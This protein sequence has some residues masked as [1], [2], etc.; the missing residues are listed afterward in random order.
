MAGG[1]EEGVSECMVGG[2]EVDCSLV[3]LVESS[4][5]VEVRSSAIKCSLCIS[6]SSRCIAA[7]A[8]SPEDHVPS[9]HEV[10]APESDSGIS[11]YSNS[12]CS[13]S[14]ANSSPGS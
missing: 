8:S 3:V 9:V 14:N 7:A 4:H 13:C 6:V 2:E 10:H 5:E 11:S 1:E 12:C